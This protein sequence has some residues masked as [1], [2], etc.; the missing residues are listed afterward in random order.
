[1]KKNKIL[2]TGSSGMIGTRLFEKL[3]EQDYEVA[4]FDRNFN[5]WR[6]ELDKLSVKGDLLN[7]K[8]IDLLPKDFDMVVHLAANARVYNL[9]VNPDLAFENIAT[10]YNILRFCQKNKI[11]NFI[12]SS[13]R[14]VYGNKLSAVSKESDVDINLCESPYT[15][16]KISGEALVY[17]FSRCYNMDCV[18]FRFSNVYGM[19]DNSDRFVPLMIDRIKKNQEIDIFGKDKSLDFTYIDDCVEGIISAI[20]RF[21]KVKNNTINIAYGKGEK[22]IDVAKLI[23]KYLNNS[24]KINIKSNRPGEVIKYVADISK[25]KKLLDYEPKYSIEDGLIKTIDWYNKNNYII[26]R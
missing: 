18:V 21:S 14:E 9:V 22:L 16:S 3:L 26:K 19:Y 13:S 17:G 4:G 24:S 6:P 12:F 11:K 8:E 2:I 25:A 10:T 20:E 15:A 23:K 7:E 5:K 1:M